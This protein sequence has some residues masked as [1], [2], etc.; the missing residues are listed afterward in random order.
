MS[1][2]T[3]NYAEITKQAEA[4]IMCLMDLSTTNRA[5][6]KATSAQSIEDYAYGV[7]HLWNALTS[8]EQKPGDAERLE[9]MTTRQVAAH[10]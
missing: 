9:A 8:G 6:Q 5:D 3:W 10:G 4:R 2:P 1:K 7:Y